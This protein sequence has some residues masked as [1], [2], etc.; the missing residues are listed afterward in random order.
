MAERNKRKQ[1]AKES[2]DLE[3]ELTRK[4]Q[5]LRQRDRERHKKLYTFV[6]V[7]LG[8]ALLFIL[9]GVLYQFLIL[10]RQQ[11]AR[12]GDVSITAE[13]FWKRVKYEQSQLQNQL[14]RYQ[15]LEQQFGNQGFFAAQISQ[16]QGTLGS[17]F[18]LGQQALNAMLEDVI[19]QQE[20]AKRG[21]V[22]TDEEVEAALREEIANSLG[23][24]TE[25][26]ATATAQAQIDATATAT[27][28]TPTP[29]ATVDAS[30][31]VTA[32][33][34]PI[35]TLPVP[36]TP[37]IITE[38][39]YAETLDTFQK[40]LQQVAGF[41]L[42][43]YRQLIRARLLREKLQE[44]IAD[45]RVATTEEAVHARH[46]LLRIREPAPTPTP[47]PEGVTPT[48]TP[49][50]MPTPTPTPEPRNEEQTLA[51][52]NELRQRLL[53]GEDFAALAAEY[54]DDPGSAAQGGDLGWFGR[55]RMVAPFEEAA[56][57]LAVDEI[58]E[59]IKTDFGY[60]IIQ[61]LERDAA[62]PKDENRLAQ[63]RAQAF[64][65]WL[66]EQLARDDIQRPSNL[67]SLLPAGL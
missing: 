19:I 24:L 29:T 15:Q 53:N 33:A 16:L 66:N 55:G 32:T 17:P 26:Q 8:A 50:G 7:A 10:P 12:V 51:L 52:A 58:S 42:D 65:S 40:S 43:E 67:V 35:P 38:T 61:V 4:E 62:H 63:E 27:A 5:R 34:T 1:A 22:V 9:I 48:P 13:Q 23:L 31:P 46:I 57:S 54:S 56:F 59:P 44:V 37:A 6:G 14:I 49:E 2:N 25:P 18:A 41:T 47:L 30:N 11:V 3:R 64:Q 39:L 20:A 21:I 28:W 36:P 60:H 45:E